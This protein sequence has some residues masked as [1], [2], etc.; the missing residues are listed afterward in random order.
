M[1]ASLSSNFFTQFIH[2]ISYSMKNKVKKNWQWCL[3]IALVLLIPIVSGFTN[4]PA[5]ETNCPGP[6]AFV[7]SQST[8]S[9]SFSWSA[10]SGASGYVVYFVRQGDNYTSQQINTSNTSISFSG[11]PSG[12]YTFY[13]ATVCGNGPSG[14]III[15][16]LVM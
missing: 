8:G 11:L 6:Q 15:E 2:S 1:L 12:T 16:D 4:P 3:K 5:I 14:I 13:F 10:I 9:A 7:T